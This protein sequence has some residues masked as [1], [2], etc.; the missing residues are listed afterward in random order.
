MHGLVAGS[1]RSWNAILLLLTAWAPAREESDVSHL[2]YDSSNKQ[3][4]G[5]CCDGLQDRF[6]CFDI[7]AHPIG[8]QAKEASDAIGGTA[9][10]TAAVWSTAL[11]AKD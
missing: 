7:S 3:E 2:S 11:E 4:R 1:L 10:R 6:S 8:L 5:S 9:L